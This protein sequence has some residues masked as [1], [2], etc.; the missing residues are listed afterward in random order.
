MVRQPRHIP[1]QSSQCPTMSTIDLT[2]TVHIK[3][4]FNRLNELGQTFVICLVIRLWCKDGHKTN[5][6]SIRAIYCCAT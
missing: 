3:G 4:R 5:C 1:L 2:M 6:P